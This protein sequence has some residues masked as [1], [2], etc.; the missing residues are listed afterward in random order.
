MAARESVGSM[1]QGSCNLGAH[2]LPQLRVALL[3][4]AP[5]DPLGY[6]EPRGDPAVTQSLLEVQRQ[7]TALSGRKRAER[8]PYLPLRG[9]AVHRLAELILDGYGGQPGRLVREAMVRAQ[10]PFRDHIRRH[11]EQ[12]G[13]RMLDDLGAVIP[14]QAQK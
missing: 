7:D 8:P 2:F 5:H 4:V 1:D 13:L 11:L 10:C 12:I 3:E 6:A 14:Q 9:L